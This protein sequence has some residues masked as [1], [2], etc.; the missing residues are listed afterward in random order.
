M[1]RPGR[2]FVEKDESPGELTLVALGPLTNIALATRLDP[3]LPERFRRLVVMGGAIYAM[4][5]SWTPAAEFN[6]YVDPESA[7]IV[8]DRWTG[9]N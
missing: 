9:Q 7:A 8:L 3:K 5:N 4:G 1:A 6:F 2:S